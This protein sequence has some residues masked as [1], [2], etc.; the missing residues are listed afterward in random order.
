M[1]KSW[2]NLNMAT[3]FTYIKG[4]KSIGQYLRIKT[5]KKFNYRQPNLLLILAADQKHFIKSLIINK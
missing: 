5:K 1:L 4:T 2:G 3:H